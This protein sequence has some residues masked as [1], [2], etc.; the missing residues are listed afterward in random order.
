MSQHK[1]QEEI[2]TPVG[3]HKV[4]IKTLLTAVET[5]QI[6]LAE[7][8]YADTKDGQTFE[9]TDLRKATLAKRHARLR[10]SVV[11]IDGD[12]T[13]CFDRM[14]KMY[15]PDY[16]FIIEQVEERQKKALQPS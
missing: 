8:D 10:A 13:N 11:S 5:E 7:L 14:Q 2:V 16:K 6:D 12:A 9:V 3:G 15:D 4:V 1:F